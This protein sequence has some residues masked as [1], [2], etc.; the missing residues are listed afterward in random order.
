MSYAVRHVLI[1]SC[2]VTSALRS[3]VFLSMVILAI[4]CG[5]CNYRQKSILKRLLIMMRSVDTITWVSCISKG[6][7]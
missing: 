7:G 6:L 4:S 1:V 3:H 2:V 5:L